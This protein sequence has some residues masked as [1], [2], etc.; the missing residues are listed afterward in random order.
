MET[1][2]PRS[3]L[4]KKL[5]NKTFRE[6]YFDGCAQE[7]LADQIRKFR[8]ERGLTQQAL[9]ELCKMAQPTI[10]KI[11]QGNVLNWNFQTILRII[12]ALDMRL[13]I[14]LESSDKAIKELDVKYC[15]RCDRFD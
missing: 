15:D 2:I 13:R 5:Q 6:F 8:K 12:N 4:G 1:F 10:S 9:G 3:K 14:T 11:E 7:E